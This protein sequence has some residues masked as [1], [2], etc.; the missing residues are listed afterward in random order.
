MGLS[1]IW[2]VNRDP[3]ETASIIASPFFAKYDLRPLEALEQWTEAEAERIACGVGA[4]PS[5][6]PQT[7]GEKLVYA[8]AE[9]VFASSG[10]LAGGPKPFLEM[11]YK[12]H[13]TTMYEIARANGWRPVGGESARGSSFWLLR[14]KPADFA[15]SSQ[16][17][18]HWFA[19]RRRRTLTGSS[20]R[21]SRL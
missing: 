2:L 15:Q 20:S 6:P 11:A 16:A 9:R 17:S 7:E 19:K 18:R 21:P 4:I 1:P 14:G 8:L 5:I 10:R 13:V 12:P 3:T